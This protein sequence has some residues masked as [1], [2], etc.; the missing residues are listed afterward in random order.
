MK[1]KGKTI[2]VN[3]RFLLPDK[4]EGIGWYTHEVV[5]RLVA[6]HPDWNFVFLFDRPFD[7]R[8]LFAPNVTGVV[9]PPPS[10]HPLLWYIWFEWTLP[11]ALKRC[12]ADV[13]FSPDGYCSLSAPV[14][15]L[16]VTHD[17]AHLHFPAEI[18]Y[19]ARYYYNHFVPRYLRRAEAVLTVSEF[20]KADI[21]HR[22]GLSG[23]KISVAGN[24]CREGF[25]PVSESEKALIREKYSSGHPYFLYLGA[26]HP[27]KNIHRLIRAFDRFKA[28]T[29]APVKLLIGGR[30]T[31]QTGIIRSAW[32]AAEYKKDILFM[33]YVPETELPK[34]TAAALALTYVSLFEGFGVPLLEAMHCDTPVLTSNVSSLP[35]V[36]GD[37]ALKVAPENTDEIASALKRLYEDA[38]LRASLVE[39]GRRR[40]THYS[41]DAAA[42][43]AEQALLN[44]ML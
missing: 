7:K 10:R 25:V 37:A 41:W 44:L 23:N 9:V 19:A 24:G 36:A 34:L 33:G 38:P 1:S 40:R 2:A 30:F 16:M 20:T 32:E 18:P 26:V 12:G 13:F 39:A 43:V 14:K 22:Y 42:M 8:F 27:R 11:A 17:L 4:L 31:W 29:G 5:R 3:A 15:T 28:E 35:E 6:W 21:V